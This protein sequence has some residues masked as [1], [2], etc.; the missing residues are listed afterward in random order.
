MINSNDAVLLQ[1]FVVDA[2]CFMVHDGCLLLLLLV[3]I[4][5]HIIPIRDS[6]SVANSRFDIGIWNLNCAGIVCSNSPK[7]IMSDPIED[8]RFGFGSSSD[9]QFLTDDNV[10]SKIDNGPMK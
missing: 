2:F 6:L 10:T 5:P 9:F 7:L 4:G 8:P 1:L 3:V